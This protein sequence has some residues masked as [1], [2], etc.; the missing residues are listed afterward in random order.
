MYEKMYKTLA[1][2]RAL[3]ITSA[4]Y[5]SMASVYASE[6]F[7]PKNAAVTMSCL[8]AEDDLVNYLAENDIF[9]SDKEPVPVLFS[10]NLLKRIGRETGIPEYSAVL[11]VYNVLSGK[12]ISFMLEI[13][14]S[15][16]KI[17]R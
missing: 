16:I 7:S 3:C 15:I 13:N 2:L 4:T 8:Y 11:G 6:E 1:C 5:S 9:V 12:K 14:N 17:Q 10:K